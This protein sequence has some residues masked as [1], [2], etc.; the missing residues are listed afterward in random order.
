MGVPELGEPPRAYVCPDQRSRLLSRLGERLIQPH[1]NRQCRSINVR[2]TK[3]SEVYLSLLKLMK[4]L[5][6]LKSLKFS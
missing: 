4:S 6:F 2:K 1:A 5:K 3:Y